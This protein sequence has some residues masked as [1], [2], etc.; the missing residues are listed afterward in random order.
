MGRECP[1]LEAIQLVG[2]TVAHYRIHEK[3]GEGGMGVVYKALD[4]HLDRFVALKVLPPEKVA[5]PDRKRRFV[6]EAKAASALN[7]PNIITIHDISEAGGVTFIAMEYVDGKTLDQLIR[8]KGL[9]LNDALKYAIQIAGAL[10]KAHGAGIVHRDLK[11]SNLMVTGEGLVKVLDFGLA[12]LTEPGVPSGPGELAATQ[13]LEAR[14]QEGTIVGTVAYMSPEQAQGKPVDARSDIFSFGAVLYEMVSGRRAF[15]RNSQASTIAAILRDEPQPISQTATGTPRD[16]EKIIARCLRKDP[17]RRFQGM[18]DVQVALEELKEE[19]ESGAL[20]AAAP[21]PRSRRRVWVWA[22]CALAIA[23]AAGAA[24][25]FGLLRRPPPG[26]PAR[27]SALAARAGIEWGPALS[28]D[29]KQVAFVWNGE[30]QDN[31]DIY[32]QLVDEATPRRLT[33]E[34]AFDYSPVWSPDGLRLA[35][36]RTTPASTEV[37]IIPAGG[38]AERRLHVSAVRC[39]FALPSMARQFCGLGWSPDGKF[40][41]IVDKESPQALNSIFLLD[42]ETR[43]KRKLTTPPSGWFGDGVSV[44]SPDGR[45]LAFARSRSAYQSDIYILPLSDRYGPRGE[46]R[47]LTHDITLIC[48]LDWTADGRSVVFASSRGGVQALWR[49][50]VSGGEPERLT[51]GSENAYWPSVSRKGDRL[52]YGQSIFDYNIWRVGAP[53]TRDP[54]GGPTRL[55]QSPLLDMNPAFSPDGRKVVWASSTGGNFEIW[56]CGSDGSQATRLTD[57]RLDSLWPQWSPNGRQI[58]FHSSTGGPAH[59]YVIGAE[60][61]APRRLTTSEFP[62]SGASWSRDGKWVYFV[63]DRGEGRAVWRV[64]AVG[65][66]PVLVVRKGWRPVFESFDG[67]VVYYG[68][69]DGRVWKVP[70]AGGEPTPALNRGKRALWNISTTGFYVLDPDAKGGPAIEFFP[71]APGGRTQTLTLP[72]EPDTYFW[73]AGTLAVSADG[74]W[75]LYEHRERNEADIML[76]ENFR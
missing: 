7:H 53:G 43:E 25:W 45:T 14:T 6:Q 33:T 2:Q 39:Q 13:T 71:F 66:S 38:G 8:R 60:G 67:K 27:V 35:F 32:V 46:P 47:R 15:Q 3:L 5:D 48:G 63:S 34:L 22:A 23:L 36:L 72:G 62:E 10:A 24:A 51:V 73:G 26:P 76:V 20:V 30:R 11:P 61:G 37:L 64:P 41:T 49:V 68:G 4:T 59:V 55:T 56:T 9:P 69:F 65:G 74:R 70:V 17:A 57:L 50:A 54:A 75:V 40:L 18:P 52:A 21:P 31:W 1:I 28:P 19:S 44:F 12:K 29:G 16:L 58:A 42:I